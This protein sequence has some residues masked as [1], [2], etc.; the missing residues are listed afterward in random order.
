MDDCIF[1]KIAR[2]EIPSTRV[3]EDGRVLA[4][5]DLNPLAPVHVV[6]I[7][8]QHVDNLNQIDSLPEATQ[9]YLLHA[10]HTVAQITGIDK[11]GYRIASNC[12]EDAGQTVQHLHFHVLGG[13]KLNVSMA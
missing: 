4:F 10:C 12:G 3:Y 1:C 6:I 8:K 11:T 5:K 9:L 2:G 7:P 13:G